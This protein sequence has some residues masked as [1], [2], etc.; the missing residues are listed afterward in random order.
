MKNYSLPTRNQCLA[1][2]NEHCV[3]PHI[4]KH[5]MAVA[6]LAAFLAQKLK[7][8]GLAVDVDLVVRV[9][10][11]CRGYPGGVSPGA[12]RKQADEDSQRDEPAC[13]HRFDPPRPHG[14]HPS[15]E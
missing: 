15:I 13:H 1:I 3:P 2:L 10:E 6:R 8:K 11:P 5:N 9:R 7:E 12:E 14:F 4:V